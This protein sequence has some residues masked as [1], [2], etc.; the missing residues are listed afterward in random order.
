MKNKSKEER[1]RK[2]EGEG[3]KKLK[4]ERNKHN[5]TLGRTKIEHVPNATYLGLIMCGSGNFCLAGNELEEKASRALHAIKQSLQ[6]EI[7]VE[8]GIEYFTQ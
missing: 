1:K 3:E 6:T 5:F 4:N 7:L 8:S 2:G